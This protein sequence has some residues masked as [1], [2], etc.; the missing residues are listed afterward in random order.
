[1][2]PTRAVGVQ[3]RGRAPARYAD[4]AGRRLARDRRHLG[5]RVSA[6]D[7]DIS[8]YG[9]DVFT[10]DA[11]DELDA[12]GVRPGEYTLTVARLVPENNPTLSAR[13][14]STASRSQGAVPARHRR[15]GQ[16]SAPSSTADP[17]PAAEADADPTPPRPGPK[18]AAARASSSGHCLIY[19]HG[20]SVGGTN[21]SLLQAL[22]ARR[23]RPRVTTAR[24]PAR[25]LRR[26]PGGRLLLRRRRLARRAAWPRLLDVR[27]DC[28]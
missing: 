15:L 24:S 20:H 23:P 21:P 2:E 12:I 22:G 25:R 7:R 17:R 8:L 10:D 11:D 9:A 3:G 13:R 1:M 27:R 18:S 16:G 19:V 4:S 14:C 5:G 26:G 6:S 28:A